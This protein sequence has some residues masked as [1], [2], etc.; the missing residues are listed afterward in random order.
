M[1]VDAGYS[2][3]AFR[4][5]WRVLVG[6]CFT[7]FALPFSILKSFLVQFGAS[8]LPFL[9]RVELDSAV[10]FGAKRGRK[11]SGIRQGGDDWCAC[12]KLAQLRF[13]HKSVEFLFG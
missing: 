4:F 6:M 13:R 12:A 8:F 7:P 5:T 9:P 2:V 3:S 1:A 10:N 11:W